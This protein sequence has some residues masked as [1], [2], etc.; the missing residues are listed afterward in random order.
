MVDT[1]DFD[2]MT[3]AELL[4]LRGHLDRAIASVGE[5]DRQAAIKAIE[6]LARDHGFTLAELVSGVGGK[7][8]RS[9]R[10]QREGRR[11]P[12]PSNAKYRNPDNASQTWSGRG[13]RPVWFSDALANGR[14]RTDMEV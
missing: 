7:D 3:R 4:E 1:T 11:A 9:G 5:R 13:R 10:A 2:A 14:T 12:S 6:N 8:G